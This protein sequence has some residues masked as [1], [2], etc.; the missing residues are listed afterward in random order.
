MSNGD[1]VHYRY[2]GVATFKGQV[3]QRATWNWTIVNGTGKLRGL[4]GRG[5]CKGSWPDGTYRWGCSGS[6]RMPR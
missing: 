2:E 1:T 4:S 3:P 5:S 6:Y